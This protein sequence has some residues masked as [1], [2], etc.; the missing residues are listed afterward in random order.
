MSTN[1]KQHAFYKWLTK[2]GMGLMFVNLLLISPLVELLPVEVWVQI[3]SFLRGENTPDY[4]KITASTDELT[5]NYLLLITGLIFVISA[6]VIPF[7][8][9]RKH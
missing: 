9:N 4:Y 1:N 2:V 5:A 7:I 8:L 6:R 3:N